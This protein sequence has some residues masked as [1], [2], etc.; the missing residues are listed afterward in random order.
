MLQF[1]ALYVNLLH[2]K[3]MKQ[4]VIMVIKKIKVFADFPKL[5]IQEQVYVVL[6][7]SL[8]NIFKLKMIKNLREKFIGENFTKIDLYNKYNKIFFKKFI[9]LLK[10]F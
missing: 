6:I 7:W 3:T 9:I 10:I 5:K 4:L 1:M 2:P 8:N